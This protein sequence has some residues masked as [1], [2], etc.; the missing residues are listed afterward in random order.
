MDL[1]F[2]VVHD[3]RLALDLLLSRGWA[4]VP[5]PWVAD[6]TIRSMISSAASSPP[7]WVSSA[8]GVHAGML[9]PEY[10]EQND[11]G[12]SNPLNCCDPSL[13]ETS[14]HPHLPVQAGILSVSEAP[15]LRLPPCLRCWRWSSARLSCS[16][17]LQHPRRGPDPEAAR[18]PG[19]HWGRR[20]CC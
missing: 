17:A 1:I 9:R 20:C 16:R 13:Q 14:C 11:K 15:G 3:L 4:L 7:I 12:L 19:C 8:G 10:V 2:K 18:C 6:L 5:G